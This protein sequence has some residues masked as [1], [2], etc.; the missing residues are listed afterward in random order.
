VN[1]HSDAHEIVPA[2]VRI[3]A[4]LD[5][6]NL[7]KPFTVWQMKDRAGR[8]GAL[9]VAPLV[10]ALLA[11]SRA[12]VHLLGHSFG[13]KVVMTAVST[14][15]SL[16][17]NV[18]SALLL[19]AAVSHY[20]FAAT[21]P[22]RNVAGGFHV[23]LQRVNRPIVATFSE[24]DAALRQLFHIAVRRH[25]DLGELQPAAARVPKYGALGGF[26]PQ[27]SPATVVPIGDVGHDY[28]LSGSARMV[29]VD[30]TGTIQ[31]HSDVSQPATWWIAYSLATAHMR[32]GAVR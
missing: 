16:S 20:A 25:H 30:G 7:L 26:G 18:E 3:P 29:G 32:D 15:A 17:R 24:H 6:R 9:G 21:V 2:A 14:P 8:V 5:P 19:Q 28:D 27:A 1:A 31:G 11:G 10:E 13:C 12:R 4:W 22:D 23:A